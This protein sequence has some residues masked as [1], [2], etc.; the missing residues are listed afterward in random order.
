MSGGEV[1]TGIAPAARDAKDEGAVDAGGQAAR[2][3]GGATVGDVGPATAASRHAA[4]WANALAPSLSSHAVE[5]ESRPCAAV[6]A[7][8]ATTAD[9]AAAAAAPAHTAAMIAAAPNTM[10]AQIAAVAAA[11]NTAV[12]N[13]AAT[14]ATAPNAVTAAAP[15]LAP[16]HG[17]S[18]AS[19]SAAALPAH[20]VESASPIETCQN[21]GAPLT[22]KYCS[23]CG[24]RHDPHIHSLVE[25]IGEA[26]ESIT[27]ADS[28][29]W[30]TLWALIARPGFLTKEFLE[31]R[32]A[33]YLPPFRLY[34]VLSVA[35]FLI[36]TA[37]SSPR[38]VGF[39]GLHTG[40]GAP[41]IDVQ[42]LDQSPA[43]PSETPEQRANR[44]CNDFTFMDGSAKGLVD[45]PAVCRKIVRDNG[46]A[47]AQAL[48]HNIPRALIVL[49]PLLALTM[50]AMYWRRRY[51]EHLLFFVHTHAFTFV[52]LTIY[53]LFMRFVPSDS[54]HDTATVLMV[55]GVPYYTYRA[56]LRVYRQRKWVTWFKFAALSLSY[57]VLGLIMTVL[58]GLYTAVTL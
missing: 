28:R 45:G 18:L 57:F 37:G 30:R 5:P 2:D 51:V 19:A 44:I 47:L 34:L 24:Q 10:A 31:G 21:C 36:A 42:K 48:Y 46:H 6:A 54:L 39:V 29:V 38:T 43:N 50:R 1:S 16:P 22:G 17:I 49:L 32:R 33:R 7:A 52:F 35:F 14:V 53:V 4:P 3:E 26:A 11:P 56:M 23:A 15:P 58:L 20:G 13:T 40:D 25:F 27:H 12:A 8:Q 55:L 9:T 41:S